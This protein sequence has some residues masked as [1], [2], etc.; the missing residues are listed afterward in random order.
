MY[1]YH[2]PVLLRHV[3]M[4]FKLNINEFI[5]LTDSVQHDHW[6]TQITEIMIIPN[7]SVV[8]DRICQ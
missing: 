7:Y 1:I 2:V 5:L 6:G 3:A 8:K 4:K